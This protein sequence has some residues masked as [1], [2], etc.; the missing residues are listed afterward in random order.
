LL[1]Y[2]ELP[3]VIYVFDITIPLSLYYHYR[4]VVYLVL[5]PPPFAREGD[6]DVTNCSMSP[7]STYAFNV[8]I[9]LSYGLSLSPGQGGPPT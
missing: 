8:S 9:Q 7:F 5:L 4:F 6:N 1:V 2:I 3:N